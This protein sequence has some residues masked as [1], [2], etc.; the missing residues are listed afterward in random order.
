MFLGFLILLRRAFFFFLFTAGH[1]GVLEGV[2]G[3]SLSVGFELYAS[4]GI[5]KDR[6][7]SVVF[8][9]GYSCFVVDD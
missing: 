6:T 1:F 7:L 3:A 5:K 9:M 8:D 4:L 2:V